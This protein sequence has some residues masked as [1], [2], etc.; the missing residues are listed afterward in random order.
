MPQP[1]IK[2]DED[3]QISILSKTLKIKNIYLHPSPSST[4]IDLKP[5]RTNSK[6]NKKG[7]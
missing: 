1:T 2:K 5:R 4:S 7:K 6:E 3:P